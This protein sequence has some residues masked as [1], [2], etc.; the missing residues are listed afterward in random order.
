MSVDKL[1]I[2]AADLQ[3]SGVSRRGFLS[4]A[5]LGA[6]ALALAACGGPSTSGNS[7]AAAA[8]VTDFTGIKPANKITFWT[9]NPGGSADVTAALVKEFEASQPDIKVEVVTAG[10]SYE[11]IAQKFQTAQVG[12]GLPDLV[13]VSDVWWFRYF[14]LGSITPLGPLMKHLNFETADFRDLLIKDYEYNGEQWA[15]PWARSTPIFFYNK[16]HWKAAGLPDRAPETWDEMAEWGPKLMG[17]GVGI[18]KAYQH[19]ALAGYAG[20]LFQNNL[21]GNGASWSKDWEITADS[22]EAVASMQWLQ[23]SVYKGQWAG[24]SSKD[25]MAD[26]SSG[27]VSATCNS[28]GPLVK[29]IKDGTFDVGVGFLPAG[30]VAGPVCPTG[31]SGIAIPKGIKPENQLAA[32]TFLKFLT[33]PKSTVTFATATGYM[34]VRKSADMSASIAATPQL[35]TAIKQLDVTRKQDNARVFLPGGDTEIAKAASV[36]LTQQGDVAA[37]MGKLKTTLEGIYTK[38]VKPKLK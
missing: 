38:E 14:L 33:E 30:P 6:G 17:A 31:G 21:W 35:E 37:E 22:K 15:I 8:N 18:Q 27:A 28:T 13:L 10:A 29:T 16:T 23:D 11:E 26:I 25:A 19:P 7:G 32:A 24:V 5:G 12:G 1:S 4:A 9:S 3:R 36:I 2:G 34:P 20:W